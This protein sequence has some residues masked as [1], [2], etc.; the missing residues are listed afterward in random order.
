M[1][2]GQRPGALRLRLDMDKAQISAVAGEILT[3]LHAT[4]LP[5]HID[6]P[7]SDFDLLWQADGSA[8]LSIRLWQDNEPPFRHAVIVLVLG[9]EDGRVSGVEDC[10]RRGFGG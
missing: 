9:F 10:V 6:H 8:V 2:E 1:T 7:R 4:E 3:G 5:D